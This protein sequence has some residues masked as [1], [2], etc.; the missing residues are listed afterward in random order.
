MYVYHRVISVLWSDGSQA[1]HILSRA[2]SLLSLLY[3]VLIALKYSLWDSRL[4]SYPYPN[5]PNNPGNPS[6]PSSPSS[7]DSPDKPDSSKMKNEK[8]ECV[9]YAGSFNPPHIGNY[10]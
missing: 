4:Y 8:R 10:P 9:C 6:S 7:P 1:M 5:N 3:F 2:V